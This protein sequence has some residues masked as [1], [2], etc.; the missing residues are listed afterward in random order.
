MKK[1]KA[2]QPKVVVDLATGSGDVALALKNELGSE[3]DVRGYD[4][5]DDMLAVAKEKDSASTVSFNFGDCT[6]LP[7]EDNSVDVITIAFGLRNVIDRKKGLAEMQ[8]VLNKEHG[9]LFVLEFSRPNI[10]FKPF[11][12]FYLRM[13]LP[14]LAFFTTGN[15]S[16]YKY[17]GDSISIFPSAKNLK[18]EIEEA[19][20]KDVSY[21]KLT[22]G[23][24]A[25]HEALP[26]NVNHTQSLK[27]STNQSIAN[28][29][30]I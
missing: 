8:R 21:R 24:V 30:N 2:C 27:Y 28:C 1:V 4:F 16:A 3:T 15:C 26:V 11:Y 13:V 7:I 25:I 10:W 29:R 23:V 18:K 14:V 19:G 12:Y 6:H 20:F 17:L 5:C 22:Q 9:K